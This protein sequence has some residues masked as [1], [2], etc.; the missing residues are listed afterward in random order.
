MVC[1]LLRVYYSFDDDEEGLL[2]RV[3]TNAEVTM[4]G[5][6][7]LRIDERS[8]LA[9]LLQSNNIGTTCGPNESSACGTKS[10]RKTTCLRGAFG[11]RQYR[12]LVSNT[13][14][15]E[16]GLYYSRTKILGTVL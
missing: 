14:W 10:G 11:L 7:L 15:T 8:K 3:F 9:A 13:S 12:L 5:L 4:A 2:R 6:T 1:T 16:G